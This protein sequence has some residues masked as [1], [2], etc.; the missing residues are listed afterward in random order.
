MEHVDDGGLALT[1]GAQQRTLEIV[2]RLGGGH[3]RFLSI[4]IV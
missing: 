4:S 3:G 2:V 1:D